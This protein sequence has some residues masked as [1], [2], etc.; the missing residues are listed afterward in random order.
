MAPYG[1][2]SGKLCPHTGQVEWQVSEKDSW[3]LWLVELLQVFGKFE[4]FGVVQGEGSSQSAGYVQVTQC[5]PVFF[6]LSM[7]S[8][9]GRQE[10]SAI[11]RQTFLQR[12]EELED[13]H[14]LQPPSAIKLQRGATDEA[15]H[16]AGH[17]GH[18][19]R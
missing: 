11:V 10:D 2:R 5:A 14:Q 8:L 19:G 15:N 4:Q 9:Q 12:L 16:F 6:I 3:G 1:L 18:I 17:L 7:D 13:V